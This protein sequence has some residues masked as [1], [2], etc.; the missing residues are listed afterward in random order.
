MITSEAQA[1]WSKYNRVT[2]RIPR[3]YIKD[4]DR[5]LYLINAPEGIEVITVSGI[6]ENPQDAKEFTTCDNKPCFTRDMEYPI[7]AHMIP[8]INEL[9]FTKELRLMKFS[10]TDTLN[11]AKDDG[12]QQ[13]Q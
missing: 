5:Y 10:D 12:N 11:N 4:D 8:I 2:A 3:A 9:I 6:F 1:R 7:S 13:P